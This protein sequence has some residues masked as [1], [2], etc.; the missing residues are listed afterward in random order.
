MLEGHTHHGVDLQHFD[1]RAN[2][3]LFVL[4]HQIHRLP[5]TREGANYFK[6]G[7]DENCL[8]L[9][10]KQYLFLVNPLNNQKIHFTLSAAARLKSTFEILLDLLRS[11][12]TE[13]EPTLIAY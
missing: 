13:P 4:P 5:T 1:I 10:P 11:V 9:L 6:L 12:D 3:L 7:F 8:A 2:E